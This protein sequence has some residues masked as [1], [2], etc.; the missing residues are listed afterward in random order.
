MN[1][2]SQGLFKEFDFKVSNT[3]TV[4][5]KVLLTQTDV[6]ADI[7]HSVCSEAAS[8][9]SDSLNSLKSYFLLQDDSGER[10]PAQTAAAAAAP[11]RPPTC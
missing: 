3:D 6:Y 1:L 11:T 8:L 7:G 9:C 10:L 5:I 4:S 2:N